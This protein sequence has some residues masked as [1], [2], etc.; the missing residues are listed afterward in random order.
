M[1]DDTDHRTLAFRVEFYFLSFSISYWE[2]TPRPDWWPSVA[3][4]LVRRIGLVAS[5][6][7]DAV[8]ELGVRASR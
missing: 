1:T 7:G 8:S 5:S 2:Q 6:E 4:E 3:T